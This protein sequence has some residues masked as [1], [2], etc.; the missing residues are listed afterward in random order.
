ML[1]GEHASLPVKLGA[2]VRHAILGVVGYIVLMKLAFPVEKVP[3]EIIRALEYIFLRP[4]KA[5]TAR[6]RFGIGVLW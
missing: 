6:R 4:L 2:I 5:E 1:F 3:S